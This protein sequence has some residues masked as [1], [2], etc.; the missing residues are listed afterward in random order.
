MIKLT[1]LVRNSFIAAVALI[2]LMCSA[3]DESTAPPTEISV[4]IT[5]PT[6]SSVIRDSVLRILTEVSTNCGCQAYVEFHIDDVHQYSDYL[7]YFSYDWDIRSMQG[8]HTIKTRV[9][10]PNRGDAWD[11]IRI[12][13]NPSDSLRSERITQK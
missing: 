10:V 12:F 4:S 6:D 13:L 7:P 8:M 3:C 9:V 2:S 11:S 5:Q 1:P